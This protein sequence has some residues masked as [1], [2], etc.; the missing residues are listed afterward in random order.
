MA[1]SVAGTT[2]TCRRMLKAW[3][4]F[5]HGCPDRASHGSST[6][7]PLLLELL[8]SNALPS[9]AALDEAA[10]VSAGCVVDAP[11]VINDE[12]PTEFKENPLGKKG[13][14]TPDEVHAEMEEAWLAGQLPGSTLKQRQRY[15][16][17][18]C[19]IIDGLLY[20]AALYGY[21]SPNLPPPAG[22]KW[23]V[24]NGAWRLVPRGG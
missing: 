10:A 22:L 4:L 3:L 16:C 19:V 21:I 15:I 6:W 1:V 17:T 11:I 24:R 13:Q 20:R 5:G 18:D 12:S 7:R 23:S 9:E 14:D 2:E 8:R